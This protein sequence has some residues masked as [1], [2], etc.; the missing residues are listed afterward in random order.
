MV[1]L[2]FVLFFVDFFDFVF[3][4]C[5]FWFFLICCG[6]SSVGCFT[7]L[8]LYNRPPKKRELFKTGSSSGFGFK[9]FYFLVNSWYVKGSNCKPKKKK[10]AHMDFGVRH[11][12][13]Y[14]YLER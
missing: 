12:F 14:F 3:L 13:G 4:V 7:K 8:N 11:V 1:F 5:G 9:F 2:F 10:I 6:A